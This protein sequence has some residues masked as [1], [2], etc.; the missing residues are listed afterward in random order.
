MK[1]VLTWLFLLQEIAA[2]SHVY[3]VFASGL[4]APLNQ[5]E[6]H[7]AAPA[8]RR[9]CAKTH[10]HTHTESERECEAGP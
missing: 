1:P 9:V 8:N 6:V 7:E 10:T 3:A 5:E 2:E 4:F